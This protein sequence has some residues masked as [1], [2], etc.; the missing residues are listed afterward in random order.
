MNLKSVL[1]LDNAPFVRPMQQAAASLASFRSSLANIVAPIAGAVAGFAS[2]AGAVSIVRKSITEASRM[3]DLQSSFA[4]LLGSV[5]AAKRRM[6]DLAR[7]AA[8]TPF[9]LP[10]VAQASK[11]LQAFTGNA[12]ATSK[13]LK[14]VGDAAAA[15]GQPLEAV[16]MWFGRLYGGLTAG[17]PLGE[18]IQNLTQLGL[19]SGETRKQLTALEGKAVST[20]DAMGI[21]QRAFGSNAGAMERLSQ[22]FNGKLST[23]RDALNAAF[24]AMG[25]PIIGAL[26]PILDHIGKIF[27]SLEPQ[28]RKVGEQ[29]SGALLAAFGGAK[30]GRLGELLGL[31]LQVGFQ[32][33][34]NFL[35]S[36]LRTGMEAFAT[37]GGAVLSNFGGVKDVLV[38]A[39]AQFGAALLKAAQEPLAYIQAAFE[40]IFDTE[41]H[42][43][44]QKAQG[45]AREDVLKNDP[46]FAG[47]TYDDIYSK[48]GRVGRTPEQQKLRDDFEEA[49]LKRQAELEKQYG[50]ISI[51]ERADQI[52]KTGGAR[53]GFGGATFNA[54]GIRKEG[55]DMMRSG[56]DR[57]RQP[58]GSALSETFASIRNFKVEDFTGVADASKQLEE[59]AKTLQAAAVKLSAPK[60]GVPFAKPAMPA[61]PGTP[62][63]QEAG[64]AGKAGAGQPRDVGDRL[65]RFGGFIGGSGLAAAAAGMIHGGGP[66]LEYARRTATATE[67]LVA[68]FSKP[69]FGPA[70]H[71]AG[72]NRGFGGKFA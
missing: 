6:T 19:I 5:D 8:A 12:L 43:I 37:M 3:E 27:D 68:R 32:S 71:I 57:L 47:K 25:E 48:W 39:A 14:L 11:L 26:K 64:D 15:V 46:R 62:P 1:T 44:W 17:Q 67:Q 36:G 21:L 53:F 2:I 28:A 72:V 20:A 4:T 24:R 9:E 60:V 42:D 13:G 49:R 41:K 31:S 38:G 70:P 40:G 56:M 34:L 16:S 10:E 45:E 7:F 69:D 35:L 52:L 29:V 65:R 50:Q 66:Q 33:A 63:T 23:M 58:I 30:T 59:L 51:K 18:P 55:L 22:T 61:L 54:E